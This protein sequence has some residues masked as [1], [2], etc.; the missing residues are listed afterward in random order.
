MIKRKI[1]CGIS[2]KP[3]TSVLIKHLL[4]EI[5]LLLIMSVEPGKGGQS[6]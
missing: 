2:I 3:K 6:L 5:D 4:K 1:K